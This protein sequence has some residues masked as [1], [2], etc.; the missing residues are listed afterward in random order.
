MA[1]LAKQI[2]A[3]QRDSIDFL[4]TLPD[5][6]R[7]KL[8]NYYKEIPIG[9]AYNMIKSFMSSITAKTTP[10]MLL[11]GIADINILLLVILN[12]DIPFPEK[13]FI[14]AFLKDNLYIPDE[15][16]ENY[17]L[18]YFLQV[19]ITTDNIDELTEI[20][21]NLTIPDPDGKIKIR[22]CKLIDHLI[23]ENLNHSYLEIS[24]SSA[25]LILREQPNIIGS[26]IRTGHHYSYLKILISSLIRQYKNVVPALK[27]FIKNNDY[28]NL[29]L[30]ETVDK[31][32][33]QIKLCEFAI[34]ATGGTSATK[35]APYVSHKGRLIMDL[36][37]DNNDITYPAFAAYNH[38]YKKA[39][40]IVDIYS[41]LKSN[42]DSFI[43]NYD[44]FKKSDIPWHK[45]F[46]HYNFRFIRSEIKKLVEHYND[47]GYDKKIKEPLVIDYLNLPRSLSCTTAI[48]TKYVFKNILDLINAKKYDDAMHV[49]RFFCQ[50][51]QTCPG[52]IHEAINI[53][54]NSIYMPDA[55][56]STNSLS[57][58]KDKILNILCKLRDIMLNGQE[59][60][61]HNEYKD[62]IKNP[63]S[64]AE[65][66]KQAFGFINY[67]AHIAIA[68]SGIIGDSIGQRKHSLPPPF[69]E[70]PGSAFSIIK[71]PI[72]NKELLLHYFFKHFSFDRFENIFR[73]AL[74]SSKIQLKAR[75][76]DFS[77]L[78]EDIQTKFD[79]PEFKFTDNPNFTVDKS[80]IDEFGLELPYKS[81]TST[82]IKALFEKMNLIAEPSILQKRAIEKDE[83]PEAPAKKRLRG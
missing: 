1:A 74:S 27:K 65:E 15:I 60:S 37:Y 3:K 43:F 76:F 68:V 56:R 30:A 48:K 4:E 47:Y 16:K 39:K 75:E 8:K 61:Y 22:V 32:R 78:E 26:F 64:F 19:E 33:F 24:A 73:E 10:E 81:L 11:R 77:I 79:W 51:I 45:D 21:I 36:H 69:D 42:K 71:T 44:I 62:L 13:N 52:G 20:A 57:N 63:N 54:Y 55:T 40:K 2:I 83:I 17:V 14:F 38:V 70:N 41:L 23:F 29:S 82:G 7:G 28:T 50:N 6:A 58:T 67:D 31:A 35:S 49:L 53:M 9:T 25:A 66:L 46:D 12:S 80:F 72:A 5:I 34:S 18:T 59:D